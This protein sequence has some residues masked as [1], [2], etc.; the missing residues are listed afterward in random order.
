MNEAEYE[1][2]RKKRRTIANII[3]AIYL[4][5]F[6]LSLLSVFLQNVPISIRFNL[7]LIAFLL[8]IISVIGMWLE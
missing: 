5:G 8:F 7:S 2:L 3:F 6:I 1:E 4:I